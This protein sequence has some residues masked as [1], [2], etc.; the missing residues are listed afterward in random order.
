MWARSITGCL[1]LATVLRDLPVL[2]TPGHS[3]TSSMLPAEIQSKD[4][5]GSSDEHF[6]EQSA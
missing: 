1:L 3:E 4:S 6:Q 5:V 2:L